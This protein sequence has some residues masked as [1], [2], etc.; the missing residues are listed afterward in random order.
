VGLG[1]PSS[2]WLFAVVGR[3]VRN[4]LPNIRG[5]NSSSTATEGRRFVRPTN[6]AG[7]D[8]E[9][10]LKK[11]RTF[12]FIHRVHRRRHRAVYLSPIRA[13]EPGYAVFIVITPTWRRVNACAHADGEQSTRNPGGW[14]RSRASSSAAGW[15]PGQFRV[16]VRIRRGSFD[17]A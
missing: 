12:R 6:R 9:A 8:M 11:T 7:E 5:P 14:V 2:H 13:A 4:S 1:A 10:T 16:V 3:F 17:R 15:L